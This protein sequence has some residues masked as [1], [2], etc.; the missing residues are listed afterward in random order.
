MFL[1]RALLLSLKRL[2]LR[3]PPGWLTGLRA[4]AVLV[5]ACGRLS[6]Q[7][8]QASGMEG[9]PSATRAN[10]RIWPH[11]CRCSPA[12]VPL[13]QVGWMGRHKA[14][15]QGWKRGHGNSGGG[16]TPDVSGHLA[17][18]CAH[19]ALGPHSPCP[20][21]R[22]LPQAAPTIQGV[23]PPG[24]KPP[25]L[26]T[27]LPAHL[28]QEALCEGVLG[29]D[30]YDLPPARWFGSWYLLCPHVV[31]DRWQPLHVCV[32]ISCGAE[33]TGGREA[34]S[35]ALGNVSSVPPG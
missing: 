34:S 16:S 28:L 19:P 27:Q 13:P 33:H 11:P 24:L 20:V 26:R 1:E 14:V 3:W 10:L 17:V 15:F 18:W 7:L 5:S 9:P 6:T 22:P 32:C 25:L 35:P 29:W 8:C 31:R 2:Q 12:S 23:P 4:S 21:S 30:C